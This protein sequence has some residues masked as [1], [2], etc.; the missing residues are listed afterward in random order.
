MVFFSSFLQLS[1]TIL[2]MYKKT[3]IRESKVEV[4]SIVKVLPEKKII[5]LYLKKTF[6]SKRSTRVLTKASI[7]TV[8]P[9]PF[10]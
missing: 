6:A 9:V 2:Y 1:N 5:I 3:K 7:A 8:S 10:L 4:T